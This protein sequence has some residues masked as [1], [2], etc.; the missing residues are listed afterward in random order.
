[1]TRN[2][3]SF[4]QLTHS[5]RRRT[6]EDPADLLYTYHVPRQINEERPELFCNFL[7]QLF[8]FRYAQ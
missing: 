6:S 4:T 2:P 8:S 7:C 3:P 1:M 5:I